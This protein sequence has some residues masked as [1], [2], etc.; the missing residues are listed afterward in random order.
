MQ[1]GGKKSNFTHPHRLDLPK[2]TASDI[3]KI[4]KS[5]DTNKVAGASGIFVNFVNI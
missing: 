5:L 1:K 4:I 2:L 3:S